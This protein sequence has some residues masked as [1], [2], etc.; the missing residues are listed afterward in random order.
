MYVHSGTINQESTTARIGEAAKTAGGRWLAGHEVNARAIL[1]GPVKKWKPLVSLGRD[2]I[3]SRR[4]RNHS[5]PMLPL[6]AF[7]G[8]RSSLTSQRE[9]WCSLR[10]AVRKSILGRKD[11]CLMCWFV[12]FGAW[13]WGFQ[14]DPKAA[15]LWVYSVVKLRSRVCLI[16]QPGQVYCT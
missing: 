7:L 1:D 8:G 13:G 16:L 11:R 5:K 9:S 10:D 6:A 14:A 15:W 2:R 4:K 12:F 3:V